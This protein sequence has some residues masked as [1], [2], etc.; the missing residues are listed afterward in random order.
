MVI[1]QGFLDTVFS[2]NDINPPLTAALILLIVISVTIF[3]VFRISGIIGAQVL[4]AEQELKESEKQLQQLNADKNLFISILSH[5]MRSPFTVILGYSELLLENIRKIDINEIE[6]F[7]NNINTAAQNTYNLLEDILMWARTQQGRIPFKPQ[8]LSFADIC[9]N[10]LEILDQKADS[11]NITINLN[12]PEGTNI[13]ADVDMLKTIMRNLVSNAIKFTNKN[14]TIN[15]SAVENSENV[16]ISVTDT[17]IGI[18]PGSLTKLFDISQNHTTRD[19]SGEKGTGLG[20]VLCKEF[21]EKHGGKIWVE[22][23]Q[24]KGSE[25]K[26]TMPISAGQAL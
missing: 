20:L 13:F 6:N 17:G 15:I 8:K 11:K 5:D 2:F 22:S 16:T 25:F 4:R 12:A 9:R 19:L 23:E 21:I 14:G 3:I 24:G 26:F 18:E 7:A 10:I 1:L